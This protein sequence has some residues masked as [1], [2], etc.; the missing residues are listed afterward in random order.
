MYYQIQFLYLITSFSNA[1]YKG[2]KDSVFNKDFTSGNLNNI[3]GTF[4]PQ[5]TQYKIKYLCTR[6]KN[7]FLMSDKKIYDIKN[8][9]TFTLEKA[10][11]FKKLICR[12]NVRLY[13][14]RVK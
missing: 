12:K 7:H 4:F 8:Y 9:Y 5:T 11:L 14:S 10:Y 3:F 1:K 13:F 2:G 6:A